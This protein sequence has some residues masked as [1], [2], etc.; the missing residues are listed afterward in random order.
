M[1]LKINKMFLKLT[2]ETIWFNTFT[3]YSNYS[4]SY[5]EPGFCYDQ[6]WYFFLVTVI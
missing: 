3:I 6:M 1:L 4:N 2:G 5:Q